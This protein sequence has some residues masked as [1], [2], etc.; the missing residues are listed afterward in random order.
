MTTECDSFSIGNREKEKVWFQRVIHSFESHEI[1]RS[2]RIS[3]AY[4]IQ[5]SMAR[6][7]NSIIF[8][9]LLRWNMS[10]ARRCGRSWAR[11]QSTIHFVMNWGMF[12]C[13]WNPINATCPPFVHAV[14]IIIIIQA[15]SSQAPF[16]WLSLLQSR[17]W[18]SLQKQWHWRTVL[19]R[20]GMEK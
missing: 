14:R 4:E 18:A 13:H 5:R 7:F 15:F 1:R 9:W 6:T 16:E 10:V 12:P 8:L 20:D 2:I 17:P 19:Q 3:S 11:Q